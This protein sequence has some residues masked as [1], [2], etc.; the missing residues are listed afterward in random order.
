MNNPEKVENILQFTPVYPRKE[1]LHTISQES[2]FHNNSYSKLSQ[3]SDRI[4]LET[5]Y[6]FSGARQFM[7][8]LPL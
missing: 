7:T 5:S 8:L 1:S 6:L 4:Y 2:A 3:N